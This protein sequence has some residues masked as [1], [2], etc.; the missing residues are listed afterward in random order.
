MA[1][2]SYPFAYFKDRS[3]GKQVKVNIDDVLAA[4]DDDRKQAAKER[5]RE[6]RLQKGRN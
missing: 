6:K 3:T 5:A 4:Y 1:L 2:C